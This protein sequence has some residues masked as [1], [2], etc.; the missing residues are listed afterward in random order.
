[1]LLLLDR[2]LDELMLC[3]LDELLSVLVELLDEESVLVE[4]T[5]CVL[6][7]DK[8][9]SVLSVLD[10]LLDELESEDFVLR[11]DDDDSLSSWRPSRMIV[12]STVPPLAP[13]RTMCDEASVMS[14]PSSPGRWNMTTESLRSAPPLATVRLGI[15]ANGLL[16]LVAFTCRRPVPPVCQMITVTSSSK[17]RACPS[18]SAPA[19]APMLMLPRS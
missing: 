11:L 6:E 15:H 8:L 10:V 13:N 7:L 4:L 9:L 3:V 17:A 2:V 5:L 18:G 1:M 14:R 16:G 19:P 12:Y